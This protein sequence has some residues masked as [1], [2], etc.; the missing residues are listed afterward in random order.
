MSLTFLND[1]WKYWVNRRWSI[2]DLRGHRCKL[3]HQLSHLARRKFAFPVRIVES[4]N[5]LPP[6][7]VNAASD[8]TFKLRFGSVWDNILVS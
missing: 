3:R 2:T 6:E 4:Y 8:E 5:K 7:N 1:G